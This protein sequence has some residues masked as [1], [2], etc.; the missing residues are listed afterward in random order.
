MAGRSLAVWCVLLGGCSTVTVEGR[1]VD[2][3][4]GQPIPGPYR[5]KAQAV[6]AQEM[7]LSCQV[8]ETEVGADGTFKMDTLCPGT[9]YRLEPDRDDL[10]LV[11]VDEVPDGGWGQPTD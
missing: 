9:A 1:V 5:I 4:T 6:N 7:A 3:L 10:W 2:G 8:F 11:D